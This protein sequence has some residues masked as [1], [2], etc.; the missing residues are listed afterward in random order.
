M[1]CVG[2]SCAALL[3][4]CVP[5]FE[6]TVH[7]TYVDPVGIVTAC[8]GHTGAGLK[9]GQKF[10]AEQCQA[11]LMADLLK[12]AEPVLKCV[13]GLKDKPY[14]LAASVSLAYNIGTTAFCNSRIAKRFNAGDYAGA[15]A[16][17]SLY[18]K[19]GGKVLPGLVK[20]RAYERAMCESK[21]EVPSA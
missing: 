4:V 21:L 8:T 10:T 14:P 1:A 7:T 16:D 5:L 17:F 9:L 6:G 13:P 12:H 18:V 2:T 3:L 20:R 19:A 11:L 15:C